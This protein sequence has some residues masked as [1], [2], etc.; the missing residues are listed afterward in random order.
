MFIRK[1]ESDN[2]KDEVADLRR[3]NEELVYNIL[4]PHVAKVFLGR[5]NDDDV[6]VKAF[7]RSNDNFDSAPPS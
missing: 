3:K 6:R 2:Q 4:P 5:K 1:N 7:S